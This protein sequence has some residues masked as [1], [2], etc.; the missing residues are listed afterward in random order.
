MIKS[1]KIFCIGDSH[2]SVFAN[3]YNKAGDDYNIDKNIWYK[4]KDY[5][6]YSCRL[7]PYLAYNINDKIDIFYEKLNE[8]TINNDKD[9]ILVAVGE[10]DCRAHIKKQSEKQNKDISKIIEEIVDRYIIFL[11]KLNT[12]YNNIAVW[13]IIP[14]NKN[15][16]N[17]KIFPTYGTYTERRNIHEAFNDYLKKNCIIYNF[18][19]ISI[20]DNLV[21]EK[22]TKSEYYMDGLHLSSPTIIDVILDVFKKN[23][24]LTIEN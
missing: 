11:K 23:E 20:Y 5:E 10:I 14:P 17:S 12:K 19:Y 22:Y 24:I 4:L 16:R 6:V 8:K 1:N 2:V 18:K 13:N 9:Y 15:Q 3:N 21:T 7:G